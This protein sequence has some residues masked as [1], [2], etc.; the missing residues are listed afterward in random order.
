[1]GMRHQFFADPTGSVRSAVS[2]ESVCAGLDAGSDGPF[3][4]IA[5]SLIA[6]TAG[7]ACVRGKYVVGV[8]G[9]RPPMPMV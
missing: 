4:R 3:V 1:M 6:L 7:V 5:V 9:E 2:F 8:H